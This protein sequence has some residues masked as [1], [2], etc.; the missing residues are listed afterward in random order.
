M[1]RFLQD[2]PLPEN[3]EAL[4]DKLFDRHTSGDDENKESLEMAL[5][6]LA[7][8]RRPLS[9]LEIS[10]A[11]ALATQHDEAISNVASLEALAEPKRVLGFLQ[12]FISHVDHDDEKTRQVKLAHLSVKDYVCSRYTRSSDGVRARSIE[13]RKDETLAAQHFEA[14]MLDV[15]IR[16]L[17]LDEIDKTYIF[18]DDL[19]AP[20]VLRIDPSL[21]ADAEGGAMPLEP[22]EG[23][24]VDFDPA[25]HELGEFFVYASSYW[26]DHLGA[27]DG[28]ALPDVSAI[29]TL[30]RKGSTRFSNW[31]ALS[32]CQ[33][34][35]ILAPPGFGTQ[36]GLHDP[37]S[38]TSLYGTDAMLR[39]LV[40]RIDFVNGGYMPFSALYAAELVVLES[41]GLEKLRILL[42]EGKTR[43]QLQSVQWLQF[44][45]EQWDILNERYSDWGPALD[46]V[47]YL[48]DQMTEEA[49][50]VEL[51]ELAARIGCAPVLRHFRDHQYGLEQQRAGALENE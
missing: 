10:W 44:I 25:A 31:T 13:S 41:C 11:V 28:E 9:I 27:S 16:Y 50:A 47:R 5:K 35:S 7:A 18:T 34:D 1:R 49:W 20:D 14:T 29:E 8:A 26:L 3:L 21:F 36:F 38:I 2:I 15:C 32:R 24:L 6:L 48:F 22:W 39:R 37:L 51:S 12:P 23:Y 19:L 30:C 45:I 4:Y 40:E 33:P 43:Q 46:L 42:L 17:L